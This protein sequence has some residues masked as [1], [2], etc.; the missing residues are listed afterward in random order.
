MDG[1]PV[2]AGKNLWWMASLSGWIFQWPHERRQCMQHEDRSKPLQQDRQ[3]HWS[4]SLSSEVHMFIW[5]PVSLW[6]LPNDAD[7]WQWFEQLYSQTYFFALS[8]DLASLPGEFC[9][10]SCSNQNMDRLFPPLVKWCQSFHG[11]RVISKP[12]LLYTW[13]QSSQLSI[14]GFMAKAYMA[15]ARGSP[16]VVTSLEDLEH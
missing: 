2:K 3:F 6:R 13:F 15:I 1:W 12:H 7:H 5:I 16:C 14:N 11:S 8:R 9:T 10:H 4:T